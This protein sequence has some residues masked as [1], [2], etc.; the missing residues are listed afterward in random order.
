MRLPSLTQVV[1]GSS[2]RLDHGGP[3]KSLSPLVTNSRTNVSYH[4]TLEGQVEQFLNIFYGQ[5][6]G[7][8][9]RFAP[10]K[11]YVPS[12]NTL[13][14]ATTPGA[15]CPQPEVPLPADPYTRL[16]NVS[17]DCLTLRIARPANTETKAKLPVVAW[18]Y[19]GKKAP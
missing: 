17:E 6:T 9:N 3:S 2:I 10:P 15:A 5:N 14:D 8:A 13:I 11:P 1:L 16:T 12:R 4:G 18:L 7:G 19:G